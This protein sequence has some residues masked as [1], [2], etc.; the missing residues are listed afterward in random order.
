VKPGVV[1]VVIVTYNSAAHLR[2]AITAARSWLR[3]GRVIVV[4]N[5]SADDSAADATEL[6]DAVVLCDTN[7]GFGAGQNLGAARVTTDVFLALNPDA[8]VIADGLERGFELL[9]A[10]PNIALVQGVVTRRVDGAVERTHG[11]EPGL[12]DLLAHRLRLRQ[13]VGERLLKAV[14][15]LLG[16]GYFSHREPAAPVVDTPFL[17]A[18][19]PLV[20]T[21]AFRAVGGFDEEF[22]LYAEDVDL[23]RRLRAAGWRLASLDGAWAVHEG[24][25]STAGRPLVRDAEWFRGHR[26]LVRQH[27]TGSRRVAGLALTLG[28]G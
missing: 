5:A 16:L 3:T 13:R 27:W 1:D 19:A 14:A 22:F 11:R 23:A 21:D 26:R 6:A 17:A 4:D 28:R 15:P 2:N 24:G 7:R 25:A 10:Q 12:A 18:V 8:M 9:S 20:R